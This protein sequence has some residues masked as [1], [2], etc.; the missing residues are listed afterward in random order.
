MPYFFQSRAPSFRKETL[1]S[2]N[3]FLLDV[4]DLFREKPLRALFVLNLCENKLLQD[5]PSLSYFVFFVKA[6]EADSFHQGI[7]PYFLSF[8]CKVR[9]VIP[10]L[11]AASLL[12]P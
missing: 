11:R 3:F 4:P 7:S 8:L 12:L 1:G 10:S 9:R 2:K 5:I 6:I